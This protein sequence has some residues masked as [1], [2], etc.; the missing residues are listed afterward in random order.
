MS[1]VQHAAIAEL[2]SAAESLLGVIDGVGVSFSNGVT[3]PTGTIDEG[4][5]YA[6]RAIGALEQAVSRLREVDPLHAF[7][8]E[9]RQLLATIRREQSNLDRLNRYTHL[10]RSMRDDRNLSCDRIADA[11]RRIEEMLR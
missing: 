8:T 5:V 9:L 7:K 4:E 10:T 11:N 3:D 2:I 6:S 1:A